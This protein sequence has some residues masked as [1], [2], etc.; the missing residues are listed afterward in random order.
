MKTL[1]QLTLFSL[2]FSSCA[3]YTP[4][5]APPILIEE[6]GEVE[7][8]V[9]GN[10]S[11]GLNAGLNAAVAYGFT[12][13]I[14]AQ[15][16]TSYIPDGTTHL[17]FLTGY[18]ARLNEKTNLRL[19]GGYFYGFGN[20]RDA[21]INFFGKSGPVHYIGSYQSYFG[22]AQ[23]SRSMG[24]M[25]TGLTCTVGHFQPNFSV[26]YEENPG[27]TAYT[28]D[29]KGLLF[30]PGIYLNFKFSE[31]LGLSFIC[32]YAWLNP[33]DQVNTDSPNKYQLDYTRH[34][35]LGVSF[36]YVL[37]TSNNNANQP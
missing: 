14:Q 22:K 7:L 4:Q 30:E 37:K 36:K 9:G 33:L 35:N 12:D 15:V 5:A 13:K 20:I 26:E 2:I 3:V 25:N 21:N 23:L 6:K 31:N 34:G 27:I 29:Q 16:Y 11:S 10:I 19:F 17:Q 32:S 18:N 8:N 28:V 1:I 24:K